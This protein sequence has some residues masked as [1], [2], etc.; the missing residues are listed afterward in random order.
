MTPTMLALALHDALTSGRSG[1]EL[2][3][4]FTEDAFTLTHPNAVLPRGG[5]ADRAQLLQA[6]QAGAS[7]LAR[8]S[9][10]VV[11]AMEVGSM[12]VLRV[13]WTGVVARDRGPFRAG[14]VLK[15]AIAQFVDTDGA[16]IRSIETY[17]CYDPLV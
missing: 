13:I 17:D 8:Q 3:A 5:R 15:A 2:D 10:E 12:A 4:L 16:R 7:L 6:S 1:A 11:S 14:Q 9:Y